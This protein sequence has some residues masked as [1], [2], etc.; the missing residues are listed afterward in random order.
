MAESD[1]QRAE[2]QLRSGEELARKAKTETER[3]DWSDHNAR[4]RARIA[5]I[6]GG[7]AGDVTA[8]PAAAHPAAG[9]VS[10][11]TGLNADFAARRQG[12]LDARKIIEAQMAKGVDKGSGIKPE[13]AKALEQNTRDLAKLAAEERGADP[14]EQAKHVVMRAGGIG[15]GAFVGHKLANAV[16]E[17]TKVQAAARAKE[18][19][20]LGPRAQGFLNAAPKTA[21]EVRAVRTGMRAVADVGKVSAKIPTGAAATAALTSL[22]LTEA[23]VA[24][25][26]AAQAGD[27]EGLKEAGWT[28]ASAG[29]SLATTVTAEH[30]WRRGETAMPM[31]EVARVREAEI[32]SRQWGGR[33]PAKWTMAAPA[34]A[35]PAE[36]PAMNGGFTVHGEVNG[37]TEPH[38]PG[39]PV[40]PPAPKAPKGGAAAASAAA[41]AVQAAP[42]VSGPAS[43]QS[44]PQGRTAYVMNIVG[45]GIDR[46]IRY[47]PAVS[48]A[49][50]GVTGGF[51]AA[52][53]AH[54]SGAT[55]SE[56]YWEGVKAATVS[57]GVAYGGA[58]LIEAGAKAAAASSN[59]ILRSTARIFPFMLPAAAGLAAARAH[60]AN[61][62]SPDT[63]AKERAEMDASGDDPLLMQPADTPSERRQR[64]ATL[65]A[66][67]DVLTFGIPSMVRAGI[68]MVRGSGGARRA[69]SG[70]PKFTAAVARFS[71]M[72]SAA[73]GTSGETDAGDHRRGWSDAARIAAYRARVPS[74]AKLPY[75]GIPTDVPGMVVA[76]R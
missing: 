43:P 71:A 74:G 6:K 28:A 30:F 57:G 62:P 34:P 75:G 27:N 3:R 29:L 15:V 66:A 52:T 7:K 46:A 53:E 14:A 17:G 54:L 56:A 24:A 73:A 60:S 22:A 19:L 39:S 68:D 55:S 47:V 10:L 36:R 20:E 38:Q 76:V 40:A 61:A 8:A 32:A 21:E 42:P 72:R 16:A 31:A 45:K 63:V 35:G 64:M 11:A 50:A 9:P 44:M 12:L 67:A 69:D 33:E 58:K 48:A 49:T 26:F 37:V 70:D 13:T 41:A 5:E 65:G 18:L 1:L 25:Y 23:A 51:R 4:I 2:R 59:P